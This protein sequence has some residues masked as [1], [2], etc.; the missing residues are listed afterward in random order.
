MVKEEQGHG[1]V[2]YGALFKKSGFFKPSSNTSWGKRFFLF[3]TRTLLLQ[4]LG[5]KKNA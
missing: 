5:A 2:K 4:V 3:N 1:D